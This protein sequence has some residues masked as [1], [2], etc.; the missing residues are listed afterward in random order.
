LPLSSGRGC[1]GGEN[2]MPKCASC[3]NE[4]VEI[5]GH[6]LDDREALAPAHADDQL[7]LRITAELPGIDEKDVEVEVSG[8]NTLTIRGQKKGA[9]E[10]EGDDGVRP[11]RRSI[12]LPFEVKEEKIDATIDESSANWSGQAGPARSQC[13]RERRRQGRERRSAGGG[14]KKEKAPCVALFASWRSLWQP[15]SSSR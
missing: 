2:T 15:F 4:I 8:G 11:F 1:N 3:G 14:S 7:E 6:E 5:R 9:P 12:R 10:E 13:P